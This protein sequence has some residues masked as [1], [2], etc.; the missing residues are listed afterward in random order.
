MAVS[1]RNSASPGG[2]PVPPPLRLVHLL[3]FMAVCSVFLSIAI[4]PQFASPPRDLREAAD[5]RYR[6]II[7]V[8]DAMLDAATATVLILLVVWTC[9]RRRVWNLPGH[10]I[11]L[12]LLWQKVSLHCV[13]PLVGLAKWLAGVQ[14]ADDMIQF[15]EWGKGI[16]AL[17]YL[18][19]GL[20]FLCLAFGWRGVANTWPWRLYF[21][22]LGVW[23]L[24]SATVQHL[25]FDWPDAIRSALPDFIHRFL[26]Y[27]LWQLARVL[28][29]LAMVN[30]MRPGKPRRHWS[31]WIAA[32]HPLLAQLF[33]YLP[34]YVWDFLHP[35]H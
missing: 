31:H 26:G 28:L 23:L 19:F 18:P 10:W 4:S 21:A 29:L 33:R 20:L 27:R 9:R 1:G 30:D 22:S 14:S 15:W 6:R 32:C 34:P 12:W 3:L 2:R 13:R 25:P 7:A 8:P 35:S 24:A 17:Q 5:P 11:A 16:Y